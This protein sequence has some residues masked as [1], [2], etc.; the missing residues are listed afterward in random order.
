MSPTRAPILAAALCLAPRLAQADSFV[1]DFSSTQYFDPIHSTG[2]WN[3][4]TQSIQG[5]LAPAGTAGSELNFGDLSDGDFVAN[6]QSAPPTTIS[7]ISVS[8]TQITFNTSLKG[9]YQFRTFTLASP[10]TI[11]AT[12]NQ[13]LIIRVYGAASISSTL[14][15]AGT[16]GTNNGTSGLGNHRTGIIAGGAAGSGGGAGGNGASFDNS[17][18]SAAGTA[19]GGTG[20]AAGTSGGTGNET[21]GGAGANAQS[22]A[23]FESTFRGGGGGGGGGGCIDATCNGS[24]GHQVGG[25]AGGGGGGAIRLLSL[26]ALS[27]TG[28][29]NVS[30]GAGGPNN[31]A[32]IADASA[33]DC[34]GGGGGGAGGAIWLQSATS[35]SGA[36][37]LTRAGGAAGDSAI[38]NCAG[39]YPGTAGANGV[40]R[41][42]G[43][44]AGSFGGQ[45][46]TQ[47]LSTPTGV[48]Y[49]VVS[50]PI[51]FSKSIYSILSATETQG[52][53]TNG[54]LG[55]TYEG[56]SDGVHYSSGVAAGDI[57]TLSEYPY[58]RFR[59]RITATGASPP[60]LT[61]LSVQ[62]ALKEISEFKLHGSPFLCGTLSTQS[63]AQPP[64]PTRLPLLYLGDLSLL[65]LSVLLGLRMKP[66]K[67]LTLA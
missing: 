63:N 67:K 20:G 45:A 62:Y 21:G 14:S 42:D 28:T 9:T 30:G 1:F 4:T 39:A 5:A 24:A 54:T 27:V 59:A 48:A 8:G 64:S 53:G 36:A 23:N 10:Y 2:L 35:V 56:S 43:P 34:G 33:S 31:A 49:V 26:G 55:V 61:G 3:T 44:T 47:T 19:S 52:C 15:A 38:A 22:I 57:A 50:K 6:S 17:A 29:L 32:N 46:Q 16:I 60:C 41:W 37:T 18:A 13:P 58:I 40:F 7:G 25:A 51:D 12:G 65:I 66:S 11:A